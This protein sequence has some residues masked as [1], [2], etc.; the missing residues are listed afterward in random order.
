MN[1]GECKILVLGEWCWGKGDTIKEA[2]KQARKHGGKSGLRSYCVYLVGPE[3]YVNAFGG[4]TVHGDYNPRLI[5]EK[6]RK[7]AA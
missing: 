4:I 6:V 2:M 1:I 5:Y 7:Y 3:D